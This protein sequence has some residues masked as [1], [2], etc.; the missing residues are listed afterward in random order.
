MTDQNGR[1]DVCKVDFNGGAPSRLTF[2]GNGYHPVW[3]PD[4]RDL[5]YSS[6][7]KAFQAQA[8]RTSR[9][10]ELIHSPDAVYVTDWSRDGRYWLCSEYSPDTQWD[11]WILPTSG[12][13]KPQPYLKTLYN[14]LEGQF[15]PDGKWIA[16]TSDESGRDEIYVRAFPDDGAKFP[17]SR[18]GGRLARWRQDGKELFYRALDGR[19]MAAPVRATAQGLEFSASVRLMSTMEPSGVMVYPY[20][21]S[22]D[23]QRILALAPAVAEASGSPL[24]VIVSW[25]AGLKK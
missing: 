24:T 17:V 5:A 7:G 14:E 9:G 13:S 21:I 16:Y 25:Q 18:G 23:G 19:L 1:Y 8:N 22:S 15:S 6:L 11:L 2:G 20:D 3:S 10:K 4:G 12:D